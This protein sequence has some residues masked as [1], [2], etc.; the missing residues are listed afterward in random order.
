MFKASCGLHGKAVHPDAAL[1]LYPV[2]SPK[3]RL[4]STVYRMLY[5]RFLTAIV[6]S[7]MLSVAAHAQNNSWTNTPGGKWETG[8]NWSSGVAPS[9]N[10]SA[11]FIT[12]ASSKTVTIDATTSGSFPSTMTL[13]NLTVSG[14]VGSINTLFLNNAGLTTPLDMLNG[15]TVTTNGMVLVTNSVVRV[16][17]LSGGSFTVDAGAMVLDN[18]LLVTTNTSATVGYS[19]PGQMTLSNGTWLAQNVYLGYTNGAHGTLTIPGGTNALTLFLSIGTLPAATGTVW[20]TGGDLVLTNGQ[21]EV[22]SGGV[23]SMTVS[24][25]MWSANRSL[26][27]EFRGSDG[28]LTI[29]GGTNTLSAFLSVGLSQGAT[30]TVWVTG[31]Q[32]TIN[33]PMSIGDGGGDGRMT[34]SNG[35]W[36]SDWVTVGA[37]PGSQGTLTLA[38][39]ATSLSSVFDVGSG[40]NATGAVW[41]TGGEL[42]VAANDS[43][44]GYNGVGQMTV[45]N[46]T[47]L[48]RDIYVGYTNG[49]QGTLTF[50]GGTTSLSSFLSVGRF[51]GGTGPCG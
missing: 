13:S 37:Q 51:P 48:A 38:G 18:A 8:A 46:G 24:N 19:G 11:D 16:D 32:L 5:V 4:L 14:R 3:F 6:L 42:N 25:G 1:P 20:L 36:Q 26:C 30:G 21:M 41:L 34:V 50:D 43:Y 49:S 31:G 40:P 7:A 15:L 22:G 45:S 2:T 44:V 27:G 10:D 35:T 23:G 9:A 47:W 39:G 17:Y 33:Y 29:P 12:N 28:T